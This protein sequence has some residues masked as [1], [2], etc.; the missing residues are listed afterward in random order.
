MI[1][2]FEWISNFLHQK[3]SYSLGID[4]GTANTLI[5]SS[6]ERGVTLNE[7][8]MITIDKRNGEIIAIGREAKQM[9]GKT[10]PP[11]EVI[12]PLRKGVIADFDL[13]ERM[14]RYFIRKARTEGRSLLNPRI[15]IC[16]PSG[17]TDVE[18]RAVLQVARDAGASQSYIIE[19]P[20]AGAIGTGVDI[21]AASGN[22]IVDIG[23]GTSEVAVIS[24]GGIVLYR[25]IK[26]GGDDLDLAI[27]LYVK[28]QYRTIIGEITAERIK[29][30]IG[31]V[32]PSEDSQGANGFQVKGR[33]LA[34]GLPDIVTLHRDEIR[35]ACAGTIDMI[36][37]IVNEAL[38]QTPPELA[39]DIKDKGIILTGGGA[40]I[41][42][43]DRLIS[44]RTGM[45]TSVVENPLT[46]IAEGTGK[47]LEEM[48]LITRRKGIIY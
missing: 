24:L 1:A 7:P 29:L 42:G 36:A 19:E 23:G 43:L 37:E 34:T 10:P 38:E 32:Y 25:S 40:L 47:A 21:L 41:N 44:E 30:R 26:V 18:K 28:D 4:L 9:L 48:F 17:A 27:L 35:E 39:S 22:M 11:L 31:N 45:L 8:S 6:R 12:R 46:A 16:I 14:L 15:A 33:S 2:L 13:T 3:F 20:M 5:Y